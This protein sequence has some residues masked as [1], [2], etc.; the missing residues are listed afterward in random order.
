MWDDRLEQRDEGLSEE[1]EDRGIERA[2][3]KTSPTVAEMKKLGFEMVHGIPFEIKCGVYGRTW[4]PARKEDKQL[5]PSWW[6]CP[7]GCNTK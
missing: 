6:Q 5:A 3:R 4:L 2:P 1:E 7:K